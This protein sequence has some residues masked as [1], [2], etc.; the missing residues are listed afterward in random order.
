MIF[1]PHLCGAKI[2]KMTLIFKTKNFK[3]QITIVITKYKI[4]YAIN[5][6][7]ISVNFLYEKIAQFKNL[8]NKVSVSNKK[9]KHFA[10]KNLQKK[11][12]PKWKSTPDGP[13]F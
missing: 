13:V 9:S 11:I 3:N 2:T 7:H 4:Q 8:T 6:S 5:M 12:I 1:F 10:S